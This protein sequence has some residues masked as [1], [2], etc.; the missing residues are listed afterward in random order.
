MDKHNTFQPLDSSSHKSQRGTRSVFGS[1]TIAS[2]DA[3]DIAYLNEHGLVKM[4]TSKLSITMITDSLSLFDFIT[5]DSKTVERT[6]VKDFITVKDAYRLKELG[7]VGF[8]L[9]GFSPSDA[10][11]KHKKMSHTDADTICRENRASN[12]TLGTSKV[13]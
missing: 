9:T 7:I 5:Q 8:V 4:M 13:S 1:E 12:R 6:P 11:T 2:A 3:F 10:L